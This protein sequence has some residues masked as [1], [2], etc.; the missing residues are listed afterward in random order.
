MRAYCVNL[1]RRADRW[2]HMSAQ[3]AKLGLAVER[4]S[5]VDGADPATAG[6]LALRLSGFDGQRQISIGAY[7]CLRSHWGLWQLLSTSDEAAMMVLEDDVVLASGI[8]Q[9]LA[10]DWL[11]RGTGLVKLE[12]NGSRQQLKRRGR[13]PAGTRLLAHLESYHSG[14]A[15]YVVTREAASVLLG[16][17]EDASTPVDELLFA[18]PHLRREGLATYQMVPAPAS[19]ALSLRGHASATAAWAEPSI[20]EHWQARDETDRGESAWGRL[21]R[22]GK[23]ELRARAA[24]NQYQVVPFG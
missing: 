1:D 23:Q 8:A 19:Q 17:P 24:G 14:S 4:F 13:V 16:L 20:T 22:R 15:A 21:L 6:S 11:P 10:D 2:E 12:T 18:L 5:A 3:C 7:A 9:Y